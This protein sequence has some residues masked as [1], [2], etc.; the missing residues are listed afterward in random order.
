[1]FHRHI[2]YV[3]VPDLLMFVNFKLIFL[4][5][6][7]PTVLGITIYILILFDR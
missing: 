1:M 4:H 5:I 2:T 7:Q 6:Y 3:N